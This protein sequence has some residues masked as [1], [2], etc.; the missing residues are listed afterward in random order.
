MRLVG[1]TLAVALG[2]VAHP[3]DKTKMDNPLQ[4]RPIRIGIL[5]CVRD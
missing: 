4:D 3:R 5:K 1:A 2:M